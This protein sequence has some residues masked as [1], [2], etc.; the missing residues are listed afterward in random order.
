MS[1][2]AQDRVLVFCTSYADDMATWDERYRRWLHAIRSSHLQYDQI[3]IIDDGSPV[4]PG[5]AGMQIVSSAVGVDPAAKLVLHHFGDRLGRRALFDFPG[6]YRSFCYAATYARH[7]GFTKVIHIESD[8]FVIS[9]RLTSYINAAENCWTA[10][11]C[12]RWSVPETCIQVMAGAALPVFFK[13]ADV[14]HEAI[15]GRHYEEQ[16]P[17]THVEKR[18]EGDR[19]GEYLGHVPRTADYVAQVPGGA[20]RTYFWWLY[21][22]QNAR[23]D[24]S[25]VEAVLRSEPDHATR[26][27]KQ[28]ELARLLDDLGEVDAALEAYQRRAEQGFRAHEV[29]VSLLRS[30]QIMEQQG[31]PFP[32]VVQMYERASDADPTRA[33]ALHGAA[34]LCFANSAN[35]Q[36]CEIA[37]RGI[38]LAVPSEGLL[39]EPWIYHYGLLDQY[40]INA[41]WAGLYRECLDASLR[42]LAGGHVP[43]DEEARFVQ[44]ARFALEKLGADAA[45]SLPN[46]S[47][48]AQRKPRLC[49][50]DPAPR[51]LL[52]ILAK[53]KAPVLPFYL[54]CLEALDYPKSSIVIYVR[55]NNN[56]DATRNILKDWIERVASDYAHV[57]FDD[58][59][60]DVAVESFGVHEWNATRFRVLGEIRN[61]S[62][63]KTAE[64]DCAFYFVV[65][66]DNFLAPRTLRELVALNL[67][68]VAPLLR[69]VKFGSHYANYH[70]AVDAQGY[71][72]STPSY[73]Q[74]LS[75]QI[76][77]LIEVP[78]VHCTYLIRADVVP[79]LHY[80]DG[81]GRHEYVVFSI[82]RA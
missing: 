27:A 44:N 75:R 45:T 22:N 66:V 71:F 42:A 19:Y 74:I 59:D 50:P 60:V 25:L 82:R 70:A 80:D 41:Y 78:V 31:R 58:S 6:W 81:S 5:W 47:P 69:D 64:H 12:G 33:E 68:I 9:D 32:D 56:T 21:G 77:G 28:F 76:V 43:R 34:R 49:L 79:E 67:P 38:D 62:L 57:E 30:G 40:A 63:R 26:A 46:P 2:E 1:G 4:L 11:W 54:A 14:P 16:L 65:D 36:G 23:R 3:L 13:Q 18:F 61:I 48:P 17:F 55:T 8:T 24:V 15:V 53:Q 35:R 29:Y 37:K 51:I 20:D 10:F 39:V 72:A 73:D 52:T 7:L